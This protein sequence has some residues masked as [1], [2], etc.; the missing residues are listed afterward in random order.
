MFKETGKLLTT[1]NAHSVPVQTVVVGE[2]DAGDC[3]V[4]LQLQEQVA[5]A[6]VVDVVG[7][8]VNVDERTVEFESLREFNE[9]LMAQ[10]I[11]ADIHPRQLRLLEYFRERLGRMQAHAPL[12][13][14]QLIVGDGF[15]A[16][17]EEPL[18]LDFRGL[19]PKVLALGQEEG[20]QERLPDG[21]LSGAAG[22]QG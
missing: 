9:T 4:L 3:H 20:V 2:R 18:F 14:E 17:I 12:P 22:T 16:V 8:K 10:I 13:H 21:G 5:S 19:D 11:V 7:P 6:V 15:V 1:V